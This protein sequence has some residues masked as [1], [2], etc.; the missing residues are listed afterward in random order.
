MPIEMKQKRRR[1][2]VVQTRKI[3]FRDRQFHRLK[4]GDGV[5]KPPCI[6]LC[7]TILTKCFAER[8]GWQLSEVII[9]HCNDILHITLF[10]H[11]N[12]K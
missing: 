10:L 1:R 4:Q 12:I 2:F 6:Y 11:G 9:P 7:Q 5:E 3:I 8:I